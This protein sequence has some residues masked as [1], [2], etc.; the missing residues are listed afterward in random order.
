MKENV[1]FFAQLPEDVRR[2]FLLWYNQRI[3]TGEIKSVPYR[4]KINGV[5]KTLYRPKPIHYDLEFDTIPLSAIQKHIKANVLFKMVKF[6]NENKFQ[7]WNCPQCGE[8]VFYC[9]VDDWSLFQGVRNIDYNY[10]PGYPDCKVF[11]QKHLNH[12]CDDCRLHPEALNEL[13]EKTS[14][15]EDYFQDW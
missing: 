15:Y 9:E 13:Q 7:F 11:S 5:E 4:A 10:Q 1:N 2:A 14:E 6:Y 3:P 12:L 8:M